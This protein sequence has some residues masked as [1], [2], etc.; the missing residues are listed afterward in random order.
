MITILCSLLVLVGTDILIC[1]RGRDGN[2]A[3]PITLIYTNPANNIHLIE[4]QVEGLKLN[5]AKLNGGELGFL[6]TCPY[7]ILQ[8]IYQNPRI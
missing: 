2:W 3:H 8:N 4:I 7:Y 1:Q 5:I 6:F